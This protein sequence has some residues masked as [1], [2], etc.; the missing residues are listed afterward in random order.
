MI[1]PNRY[2]LKTNLPFTTVDNIDYLYLEPVKTYLYG[3]SMI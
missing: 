1:K 3:K 2:A